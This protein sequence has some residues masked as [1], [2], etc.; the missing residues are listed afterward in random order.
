MSFINCKH[1]LIASFYIIGSACLLIIACQANNCE[2][3]YDTFYKLAENL[4]S[5][6]AIPFALQILTSLAV[7]ITYV[8]AVFILIF[9]VFIIDLKDGGRKK[10]CL[11]SLWFFIQL[12]YTALAFAC[13]L[14]SLPVCIPTL[15]ET[16]V[17]SVMSVLTAAM[18][19]LLFFWV[20]MCTRELTNRSRPDRWLDGHRRYCYPAFPIASRLRFFLGFLVFPI[21]AFFRKSE[22][23]SISLRWQSRCRGNTVALYLLVS[24][25][26]YQLQQFAKPARL[27]FKVS[28][29]PS[30]TS[31][32]KGSDPSPKHKRATRIYEGLIKP[33]SRRSRISRIRGEHMVTEEM[34]YA[35]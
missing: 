33:P 24:P 26:K 12:I 25:R 35:A 4:E 14:I 19:I 11:N 15:V 16:I 5:K 6:D 10:L 2:R 21:I 17:H 28:H 22:K 32:A 1:I 31:K 8:F 29:F 27:T 23:D 7:A 30:G 3:H 18:T 34:V 20:K 9:I 13:L